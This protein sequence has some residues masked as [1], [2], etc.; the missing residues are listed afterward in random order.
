MLLKS[1][2]NRV[3]KIQMTRIISAEF[4]KQFY[5]SYI[6]RYFKDKQTN[7]IDPDEAAAKS[8]N[9]L[10]PDEAAAKS[11]NSLDPD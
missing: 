10:D 9:S 5:S 11:V 3:P 1:S 8:A 6:N 7:S 4:P 2:V